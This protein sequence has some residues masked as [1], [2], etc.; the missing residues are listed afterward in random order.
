M[1]A[2]QSWQ[3]IYD[4]AGAHYIRGLTKASTGEQYGLAEHIL[5]KIHY[6][7]YP[8]TLEKLS[9]MNSDAKVVNR[10]GNYIN[11]IH[12]DMRQQ[13]EEK[14]QQPQMSDEQVSDLFYKE[15]IEPELEKLNKAVSS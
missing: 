10:A 15:L 9:L 11:H 7:E 6:A 3:L 4:G 8:T 1:L 5:N 2:V 14:W 13:I 12:H